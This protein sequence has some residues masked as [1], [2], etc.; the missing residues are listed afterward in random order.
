VS[1]LMVIGYKGKFVAEEVCLQLLNLREQE[2]RSTPPE[3]PTGL[4]RLHVSRPCPG[5]NQIRSA[6]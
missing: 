2:A 4:R 1:E 5:C 3:Q 6:R